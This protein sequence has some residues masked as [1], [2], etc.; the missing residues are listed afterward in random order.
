MA[1]YFVIHRGSGTFMNVEEC[2]M[3]RVPD[4]RRLAETIDEI[5][6]GCEGDIVPAELVIKCAEKYNEIL[7]IIN[8]P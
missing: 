2:E 8:S 6:F 4:D 7:R 5:V 3:V 1:Q